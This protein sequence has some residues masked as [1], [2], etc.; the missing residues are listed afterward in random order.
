ME[1]GS[2]AVGICAA[3][4]L[5]PCKR[6]PFGMMCATFLAAAMRSGS[7]AGKSRKIYRSTNSHAPDAE[8][9]HTEIKKPQGPKRFPLLKTLQGQIERAVYFAAV[10]HSDGKAGQSRETPQPELTCSGR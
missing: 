8:T 3:W 4:L 2:G 5:E 10:L 7:K 1:A 6:K 9:Y